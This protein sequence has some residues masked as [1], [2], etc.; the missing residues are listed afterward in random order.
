MV[1]PTLFW[2]RDV[3][4]NDDDEYYGWKDP[5]LCVIGKLENPSLLK[6]VLRRPQ[7]ETLTA[8]CGMPVPLGPLDLTQHNV[9]YYHR[10]S[11][12]SLRFYRLEYQLSG[13][14]S[15]WQPQREFWPPARS[16]GVNH[17][18]IEQFNAA[19][20]IDLLLH[21]PATRLALD[22][23]SFWKAFDASWIYFSSL[24][25]FLSRTL[26]FVSGL[27][28]PFDYDMRL[29][30]VSATFQQLD[31]RAEQAAF[32]VKEVK[33]LRQRGLS[34]VPV[35][36][37]RY[38]TFFNAIWLVLNDM[39]IGSAFGTFLCENHGPLASM[40]DHTITA[41]LINWMQWMLH[42][43]DAW[44]A[45]L[46]LNTE[47]SRFYSRT[48]VELV[49]MWGDILHV[50]SPHLPKLV[51]AMGIA[52]Y[53]GG[54]TMLLSLASDLLAIGT[55][56]IYVA[57][58][59]SNFV[60]ARFLTT[61]GSLWRLFRGKRFNVLRNRTDPWAYDIDQLLFGTILFT[62]VAFLF[63]TVFAYYALFAVMRFVTI[64]LQA[65]LETALAFMNHFPLFALMQRL[66]DPWRLPG[67][68]YLDIAEEGTCA[69][70][71]EKQY[72]ITVESQP[73]SFGA[74]FFQYGRLLGRLGTH[75]NPLRL[76]WKLMSG[77]LVRPIER[78]EIRYSGVGGS[79]S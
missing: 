28:I 42:W 45:G 39:T 41:V 51:Y 27:Y 68:I 62:L 22:T 36:S 50:A 38:T 63:P 70:N 65:T 17:T 49:G 55:M 66:K 37:S 77:Q 20:T 6:D 61:F 56:H 75:Y 78:Y 19:K 79:K 44:P 9:V 60:Y 48:L 47:L 23:T 46:K 35:F 57:Y 30:D 64:L 69:N 67:G 24:L 5:N 11:P 59:L 73:V 58:T 1:L 34:S 33:P 53:I 12:T 26:Y 21:P 8:T 25:L 31:V 32:F 10:H 13:Q 40:L 72:R 18:V 71:I 16:S 2:P 74:I 76:L 4:I 15:P 14:A 3:A 7:C 54:F 43:L 52:S 29:K